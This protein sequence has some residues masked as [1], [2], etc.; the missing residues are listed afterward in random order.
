MPIETNRWASKPLKT[1]AIEFLSA[2]RTQFPVSLIATPR[3]ELKCRPVGEWK[4]VDSHPDFADFDQV[5]LT[6][7]QGQRIEAVFE[8]GQGRLALRE[9]MFIAADAPLLSFLE[10]ADQQRFRFLVMDSTV[11]GMVTISD[12][13]KLPVYSVLFSLLIAVEMSLM[14][15]IRKRCGKDQDAWLAR[16]EDNQQRDIERHWKQAQEKNLNIDRLNCASFHHEIV[17]AE[18]FGLFTGHAD[19]QERLENL[20]ALRNM[21]YHAAEFAPNAEEA[22]KIPARVRDAHTVAAWLQEQIENQST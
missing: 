9:D 21:V 5:P 18:G 12:I 19:Q 8:R 16:L 10:S 1:S 3:A 4:Q 2:I 14:E 15:W 13:Q 7:G 17:A 22:L 20:K 11:S 6:D